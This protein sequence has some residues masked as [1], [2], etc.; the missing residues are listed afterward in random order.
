MPP[1]IVSVTAALPAVDRR[2]TLRDISTVAL[3]RVGDYNRGFD[4]RILLHSLSG[5][6][7]N[8]KYCAVSAD[9]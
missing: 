9:I 5:T 3:E 4:A 1:S 8:P 7:P 6:I 2:L